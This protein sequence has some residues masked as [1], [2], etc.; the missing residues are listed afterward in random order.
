M[1]YGEERRVDMH[2]IRTDIALIKQR[3]EYIEKEVAGISRV[4]MSKKEFESHV[5]QDRWMF[6]VLMT[7]LVLIFG[8]LV[9][10]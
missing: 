8:K 2:E 6:G 1:E 10:G 7:L 5:L 3:S 9:H 4:I